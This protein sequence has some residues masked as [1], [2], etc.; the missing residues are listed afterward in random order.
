MVEKYQI[1]FW[2]SVSIFAL[3]TLTFIILGVRASE[4]FY[5]GLLSEIPIGI[6]CYSFHGKL[7]TH[8]ILRQLKV[9]WGKVDNRWRNLQGIEQSYRR[10]IGNSDPPNSLDDDT[11]AD[12]NMDSIFTRLDRTFTTPGETALYEFLRSPKTELNDLTER[13]RV[14]NLLQS[15][16]EVRE[17]LQLE[18]LPLG[19]ENEYDR[20]R[21]YNVFELLWAD[22]PLQTT[23]RKLFS[24][25]ALLAFLAAC[26]PL[27]LGTS[28]VILLIIPFF[29]VNMLIT[30]RVRA[31]EMFHRLP[32]IRYLGN[33]IR[34]ARAIGKNLCHELK[35]NPDR[36]LDLSQNVRRIAAKTRILKPELGFWGDP[37]MIIFEY[38]SM[39][40][41]IE[42][43]TYYKLMEDI[44][45][46]LPELR[47]LC[48]L[49]GELDALQSVASFRTEL[50]SY[51]EPQFLTEDIS[52]HMTGGKH[53]LLDNPIPNS[54]DISSKGIFVSGSNMSGKST[55]L[56]TVAV[57]TVMAQTV[58]TCY[59][60][61]YS[62]ACFRI[63]SS[64]NR[65]DE[66][67]EGKS[68]YL[69]EAERL[70]RIV[71]AMEGD[72]PAL[73]IIDE[74]FLGT[75]SAERFSASMAILN[76]LCQKKGVVILSSHDTELA[77]LLDGKYENYHFS[78]QFD[79]S[80]LR[81]DYA[82]KR[83]VSRSRNAIKLLEYLKYP[84]EIVDRAYRGLNADDQ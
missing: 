3:T 32:S 36:L 74:L 29:L 5:I 79:E 81:F 20:K 59:A 17:A 58:V 47:E 82:L 60:D 22:Q 28:A 55:F 65:T 61:A 15:K 51:A 31:L 53:P 18:F 68:Y 66:L 24:I 49:M 69:V 63:I 39:Y 23:F 25:L 43:R 37:F 9:Q 7:N 80:G 70:L 26:S 73:C 11:W 16:E 33:M 76:Y 45:R 34:R 6:G 27:F 78:D 38:I 56:R 54:I 1:L 8:R 83:G 4:L 44:E 50:P 71:K 57:N 64:L 14:L 72:I 84:K 21:S 52:L 46:H 42:V 2:L 35:P 13:N 77:Q 67:E 10:C 30:H 48:R 40:F 41:L 75:N 12:L 62:G 19:R